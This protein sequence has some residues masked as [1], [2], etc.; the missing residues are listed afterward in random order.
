MILLYTFVDD[1]ELLDRQVESLGFLAQPLSDWIRDIVV[2]SGSCEGELDYSEWIAACWGTDD[3]LL[4]EQD[5]VPTLSQLSQAKRLFHE[6]HLFAFPY[7]L[8]PA[9]TLLDTPVLSH[10]VK[11]AGVTR[12]WRWG[13][14][15]D[16]WADFVGFGFTGISKYIQTHVPVTFF[17]K[18]SWKDL[19]TQFSYEM[20]DR[21][22][23]W[24]IPRS[25]V[26]HNH[27]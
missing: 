27:V 24:Y 6:Q 3:L 13:T 23:G 17:D 4:M 18:K 5:I 26:R 20:Q 14:L 12:G 10:R 7:Y 22:L 21:G 16:R 19:D 11:D 1:L 15:E 9:S 8:Y 2:V 25:V